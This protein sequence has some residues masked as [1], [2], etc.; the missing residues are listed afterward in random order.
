MIK[1]SVYKVAG[2]FAENKDVAK[3]LRTTLLMP[4]LQKGKSVTLDF[5]NVSLSTQSF[6][7]ALVSDAIRKHGIGV[8]DQL[9]FK[10]CNPAIQ[11]LVSTVCDYMQDTAHGV[12]QSATKPVKK[13]RQNRSSAS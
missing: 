3:E 12:E 13:G 7:H 6:V 8:L 4:A 5:T 9:S 1:I 11:A 2:D 10:G